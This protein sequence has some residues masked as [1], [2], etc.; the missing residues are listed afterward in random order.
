MKVFNDFKEAIKFSRKG[1]FFIFYRGVLFPF[2][3]DYKGSDKTVLFLPGRTARDRKPI[4]VFQRSSYF[5][6]V[7]ANVVSCFDPTLFWSKSLTL[8]WFQGRNSIFYA[9]LLGELV[10]KLLSVFKTENKNF[11][12]YGT[13]GGGIPG[14]NIAKKVNECTLYV[15]NVQVDVSRYHHKF[16]KQMADVSYA[17]FSLADIL[18]EMYDRLSVVNIDGGFDLIYSQNKSDKF[19][20]ENHFKYYCD[21]HKKR[22]INSRFY[23]Y[24]DPDTGHDPL[25]RDTELLII[26]NIL[27][28][29]S[30]LDILPNSVEVQQEGI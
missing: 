30:I 22:S 8:G 5:D 6:S 9:D 24:N 27:N 2:K 29:K 12:L 11:Y 21:E 28:G 3:W 19:H 20:Y 23:L 15:S 1:E 18:V 7:N 16:F 17:Q 4:P 13:S 10:L 25:P 14:F 26:D